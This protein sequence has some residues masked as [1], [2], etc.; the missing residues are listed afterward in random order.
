MKKNMQTV[1]DTLK[2]NWKVTVGVILAVIVIAFSVNAIVKKEPTPVDTT[3]IEEVPVETPVTTPA[4]RRTTP[5]ASVPTVSDTRTYT[6]MIVAYKDRTIQFNAQCQVPP[7][8]QRG[9]KVGTDVMLDNRSAETKTI[10]IGGV[11][12]TLNGYGW[13]VVSLNSAGNFM[14]DCNDR[15]NV[16]TITVQQ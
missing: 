12:H 6:E 11:T 14:V 1:L 4:R 15:Q 7:L 13:K 5:V 10:I 9:F 3:P 2:N 16:T 8:T